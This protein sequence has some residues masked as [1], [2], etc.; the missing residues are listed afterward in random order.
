MRARFVYAATGLIIDMVFPVAY[1]LLLASLLFRLWRGGVP[2]Y[3]LPSAMAAADV[4]GM[5][6]SRRWR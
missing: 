4:L 2:P 1:G 6:P 5:R 3:L